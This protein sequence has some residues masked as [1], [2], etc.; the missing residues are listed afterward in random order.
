MGKGKRIVPGELPVKLKE[1]RLALDLSLEGMVS[2]LESELLNLGY[3]NVN[4]H[5][6]YISDFEKGKREPILPVLLAY[7]RVSKM[8]AEVL[9]DDKL[10]LTLTGVNT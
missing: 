9:I 7:A 2:I 10:E 8:N 4:L 3:S 5:S 6:G 1:I